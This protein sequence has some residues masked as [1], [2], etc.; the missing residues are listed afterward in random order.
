MED[1]K[2]TISISSKLYD[3]ILKRIEN[4]DNEFSSPEEYV[5]YVLSELFEEKS[6]TYTKE[7][8]EE[9]QKKLRDMG[10]I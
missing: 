10:Y 7:E 8:Q 5:D 2:K 1:E 9:I 3:A 6:D 4:S